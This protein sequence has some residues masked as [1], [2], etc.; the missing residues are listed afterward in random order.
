MLKRKEAKEFKAA[1]LM[2]TQIAGLEIPV[3][4]LGERPG[5]S[6]LAAI[7]RNI[8]AHGVLI[9]H[10]NLKRVQAALALGGQG[11]AATG[12]ALAAAQ[13]KLGEAR[14]AIANAPHPNHLRLAF[15]ALFALLSLLADYALSWGTLPTLFDLDRA[16]LLGLVV[17]AAPVIAAKGCEIP[18][19]RLHELRTLA[20]QSPR[21]GA[22]GGIYVA[23]MIF[24][25][26]LLVGNVGMIASLA[27][28]REEAAKIMQQILVASKSNGLDARE[29][30]LLVVDE[31]ITYRAIMAVGLMAVID[32]SLFFTLF[33]FEWAIRSRRRQAKH[34]LRDARESVE[35]AKDAAKSALREEREAQ[36][37]W[38]HREELAQALVEAYTSRKQL[39]VAQLPARSL[40]R[41]IDETFA[42]ELPLLH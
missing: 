8:A 15:A 26:A 4:E 13:M 20:L 10:T 32:T 33:D 16:T 40:L 25:G 11:V 1:T 6:G 23:E 28:A 21:R 29:K 39:E 14:Q 34:Q 36:Y 5:E 7:W 31:K 35:Q 27:P 9:K 22:R 42:A 38:E 19:R 2:V 24:I 37:T 41:Q 17:A 12:G 30:K 18:L 3:K